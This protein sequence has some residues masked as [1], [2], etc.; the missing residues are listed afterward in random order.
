MLLGGPGTAVEC[1]ETLIGD[2][3]NGKHMRGSA[4]KT[5]VLGMMQRDSDIICK[6]VSNQRR[7]TLQPLITSHVAPG[8]ELYTDELNSYRPCTPP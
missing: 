2:V 1:D 5:V 3:K 4:G 7:V 8:G 6:V